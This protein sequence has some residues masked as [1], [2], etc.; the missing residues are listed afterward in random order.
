MDATKIEEYK[1]R[2][3]KERAE[4]IKEIKKDQK[5]ED[6][7]A[8]LDHADEEANEAESLSN[9]LAEAQ[10]L[11]ERVNDIDAALNKIRAGKYGACEKCGKE[12]GDEVLN[13]SPESRFC[14][15]CK[16]QIARAK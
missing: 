9:Q 8:D 10:D 4:L 12:I 7:G 3:E 1:R 5:P 14:K 15:N 6:F 11:K 13:I 2:L 16:K